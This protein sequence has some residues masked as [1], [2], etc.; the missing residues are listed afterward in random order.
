VRLQAEGRAQLATTLLQ[1]VQERYP[2]TPAAAEAAR[3]LAEVRRNVS[4][5]SGDTEL[6]VFGTTYGAALA[7]ALWRPDTSIGDAVVTGSTSLLFSGA[8]NILREFVQP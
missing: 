5:R 8:F 4:D 2:N 1:L 7:E 6:M 3:L